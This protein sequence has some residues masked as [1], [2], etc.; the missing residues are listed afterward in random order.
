LKE[1]G[2]DR[3]FCN[4]AYGLNN[5]S[6]DRPFKRGQTSHASVPDIRIRSDAAN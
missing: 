2:L 4:V 5:T 6:Y 1:T 3:P